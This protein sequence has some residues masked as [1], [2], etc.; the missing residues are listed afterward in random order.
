MREAAFRAGSVALVLALTALCLSPALSGRKE[1]TNWDDPGY[2]TAQPLVQNLSGETLRQVF[3]PG[4]HVM[5]NYHPLTV[6]SL[7]LDYRRAGLDVRAYA[8]TN[9]ALHLLNTL[10]VLAFL[11]RLSGRFA[12]GALAAL[13]F[14]IHPMHVENVAWIPGRKDVLY[15]SFFLIACLGYLRYLATARARW[16]GFAFGAFVLS[17]LSKGMAVSLPPVL[18]LLDAFHGRK[19]GRR[20]LLEK[21]PFVLVALWIGWVAIRLQAKEPI[22][23]FETFGPLARVEL[24]A[25]GFLGY[26]AKLLVP[27]RL[28]AFYPYPDVDESHHLPAVFALMPVLALLVVGV[29]LAVA[30]R[31]GPEAFRVV[32][33]GMGFFVVTVALVLQF[34]SFGTAVMAD[35]YSYVPYVG[36]LFVLAWTIDALRR[37]ARARWLAIAAATAYSVALAVVCYQRT[38]VWTNSETLWTDVIDKYPFR[39]E[40]ADGRVRV[41]KR[42]VVT[43]YENRGNYYREHGRIEE[44]VRDYDLL[45]K[46]GVG[47]SGA[48]INMGNV[49]AERGEALLGAKDVGAAKV[50]FTKALDMYSAAI[51][52][53]GNLSETFVNRGLTYAAMGDHEAALADFRTALG[54]DPS[55]VEVRSNIVAEELRL[56]RYDDCIADAG[57]LLAIR[58]DDA[59]A[60]LARGA[61]YLALGRFAEARA[62]LETARAAGHPGADALL[63][64]LRDADR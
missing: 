28:S 10:L 61:A 26:W 56:Q 32:L 9:L 34:V 64:R 6:L 62:D 42:G 57:R 39:I 60:H 51:A 43:A 5:F 8:A 31:S 21:V 20:V 52:R 45:V 46:A 27:Y 48:Y 58:P 44:A 33:F 13:W 53:G 2:V 4:T 47:D 11:H 41:T 25:Y 12:V 19:I 18:L 24:A 38:W 7:A 50:E 30:R 15:G 3:D 1:F 35:R 29:P 23:D 36:A 59:Q 37:R 17:C 54:I 14:G 22:A 16:L 49:H 40:E 63:A 55:S